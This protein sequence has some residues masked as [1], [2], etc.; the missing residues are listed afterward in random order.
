MRTLALASTQALRCHICVS[1]GALTHFLNS[2]ITAHSLELLPTVL[3]LLMFDHHLQ[4]L[5]LWVH[6][7]FP[8]E[9]VFEQV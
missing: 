5:A 1:V 3:L 9:V 4:L 2:L 7:P 6:L 8:I